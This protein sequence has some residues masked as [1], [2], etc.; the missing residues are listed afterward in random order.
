MLKKKVFLCAFFIVFSVI[1]PV[2]IYAEK[3]NVEE[4][5][6]V[7]YRDA[8][9]TLISDSINNSLVGHY[10]ELPK[11]HLS[12]TKILNFR[13]IEEGGYSFE[14]DVQV[15]SWTT[16]LPPYGLDTLKIE[17]SPAGVGVLKFEHKEIN[18]LT[19]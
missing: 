2:Y 7:L 11:Y 9:L 19:E 18:S 14:A 6:E 13:R 10:G 4:S 1:F 12:S 3:S 5:S 16:P 17:I 8:V 15:K